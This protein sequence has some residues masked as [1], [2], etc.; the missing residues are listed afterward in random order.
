M[1]H[2]TSLIYQQITRLLSPPFCV[3]C[4]KLLDQ[5]DV[6]CVECMSMIRPV[7]SKELEITKTKLIMVSGVSDYQD[8][9]KKLVVAKTWSD[10]CASR[11]LG[12]LIWNKTD[13]RHMKFDYLVPVPLHWRRYAYRGFNQ[14]A[15]IAHVLNKQSGKLVADILKRVRA[16]RVQGTLSVD[17]RMDNVKNVFMHTC[18][19]KSVYRDKR[20]LLV[21]DVM[22]SGATLSAA[23]RA[24]FKLK[25]ASINA[26]VACRRV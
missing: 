22:T 3:Y 25:P 9:I 15:E 12:Q 21:D 20:L 7:V 8:P 2:L 16:T 11:Q 18:S 14:A 13:V 5:R 26:V 19:D 17:E 6:F 23:A 10:R 1:R 24:L 4:K